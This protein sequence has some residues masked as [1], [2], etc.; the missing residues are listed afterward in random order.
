MRVVILIYGSL[1]TLTGGYLYDRKL[2]EHLRCQGHQ[3]EVISKPYHNYL[4]SLLDNFSL[5]LLRQLGRAPLP[6]DREWLC[7]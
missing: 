4:R 6:V 2:I 1:E 3:V 5:S 7:V